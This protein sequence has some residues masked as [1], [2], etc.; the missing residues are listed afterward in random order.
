M[1]SGCG[2]RGIDSLHNSK[3]AQRGSTV[4]WRGPHRCRDACFGTYGW[5]G[6][7]HLSQGHLMRDSPA[8]SAMESTVC[9]TTRVKLGICVPT[10]RETLITN[11]FDHW[12][13]FW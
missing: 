12:V 8:L 13:P 7:W 6:P 11:F 5:S 3:R 2:T 4:L 9:L 1:G 10:V